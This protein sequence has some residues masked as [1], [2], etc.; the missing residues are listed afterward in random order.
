MQ[1]VD[2]ERK[3]YAVKDH[4]RNAAEQRAVGD[5]GNVAGKADDAQRN[6]GPHRERRND[7]PRRKKTDHRDVIHVPPDEVALSPPAKGTHRPRADNARFEK[8]GSQGCGNM[9]CENE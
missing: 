4:R 1:P 6:H 5:E 3:Q 8:A 9:E 7:E 2:V